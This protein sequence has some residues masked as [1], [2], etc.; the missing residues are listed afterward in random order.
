MSNLEPINSR[1]RIEAAIGRTWPARLRREAKPDRAW[2]R[3][4]P[5]V[6]CE[7]PKKC[8]YRY[9]KGGTFALDWRSVTIEL[10]RGQRTRVGAKIYSEDLASRRVAGVQAGLLGPGEQ[11]G[12]RRLRILGDRSIAF[13]RRKF[14]ADRDQELVCPV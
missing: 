11:T 10:S 14:V 5:Y 1:R 13:L 9:F 4:R 2:W 12:P 6:R 7:M 3:R 8:L